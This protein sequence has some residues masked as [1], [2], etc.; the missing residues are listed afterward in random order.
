MDR[1]IAPALYASCIGV[2]GQMI[3]SSRIRVPCDKITEVWGLTGTWG[4]SIGLWATVV[5]SACLLTACG[6]A[7]SGQVTPTP[8]AIANVGTPLSGLFQG[9]CAGGR[10]TVGD[11]GEIDVDLRNGI[12]TARERAENW[13]SDAV[14]VAVRVGC[15]LLEPTFHWRATFFSERIQTYFF[16]DTGETAVAATGS[17]ASRELSLDGVSFDALGLSLLRAGYVPDASLDPG[18][19][20]EVRTNTETNP[21]GPSNVPDGAIVFH[22]A[23]ESR[24]EIVDLF[25]DASDGTVYQYQR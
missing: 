17:Q 24:G 12:K 11:L 22:V 15:E 6:V 14:L 20:V 3:V 25:V 1:P 7:S 5:L 8:T 19:N 13:Q 10:L 23:L 4:Q 16:S 9:P 21:F 2:T 18:S